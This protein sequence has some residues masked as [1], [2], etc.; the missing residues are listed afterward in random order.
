MTIIKKNA[1]FTSGESCL[2]C[3]VLLLV[4]NCH[5]DLSYVFSFSRMSVFAQLF[6]LCYACSVGCRFRMLAESDQ[7]G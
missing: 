6:L 7:E 2:L 3:P 1:E 4:V 5:D